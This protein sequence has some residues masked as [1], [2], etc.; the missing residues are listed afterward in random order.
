MRVLNGII[1]LTRPKPGR[2]ARSGGGSRSFHEPKA[3][4][5]EMR[6]RPVQRRLCDCR[7]RLQR[8]AK[9]TEG[10][11]APRSIQE[12]CSVRIFRVSR[13]SIQLGQKTSTFKKL[14][15]IISTQKYLE[16]NKTPHENEKKGVFSGVIRVFRAFRRS[17]QWSNPSMYCRCNRSIKVQ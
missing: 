16:D 17:I 9:R 11:P 15:D 14:T 6:T 4:Y 7:P 10:G 8:R 1:F 12:K 13:Q 5:D 3:F 2:A